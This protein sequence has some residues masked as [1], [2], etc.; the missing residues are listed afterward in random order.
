MQFLCD[1]MLGRLAT[2]L[3]LL[4]Y[5]TVYSGAGDHELARKSR[6]EDRILLTR[7]AQL[8]R[9]RGIR[10]LL[11]V[12]DDLQDQL[13]QVVRRFRLAPTQALPRCPVCNTSLRGLPKPAARER[14]PAY[15]HEHHTTFRECPACGKVYWRGSHWQRIQSTLE[16]LDTED[17]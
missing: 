4:G 15:V 3:R 9:R 7:D 2:W 14:V 5:D 17:E 8:A 6:A 12:S 11:I 16:S 10:A 13:R 1:A